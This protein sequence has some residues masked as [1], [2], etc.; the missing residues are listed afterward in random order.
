MS[1]FG[2]QFSIFEKDFRKR[3]APLGKRM[4]KLEKKINRL[5][6][7]AMSNARLSTVYWNGLKREMNILYAEMNGV[8]DLWSKKQIP[9]R[10]RK[11]IREIQLRIGANKAILDKAKKGAAQVVRSTASNQIMRGLYTSSV[12]SFLTSS[13][14]GRQNLR[15]LFI[16]TQQTLVEESLVNVAVGAGFEMGDL[17]QAKRLL[18]SIF[19]SPAWN[20][21]KNNQFVQAGRFKYKPSYYAELVARTKF[22]QAHSQA[23]LVQANN[24]G[25]DLV[26]V[27]S[28]NTTTKICMDFEGKIFSIRGGSKLFPP[29]TDSP[30]YHP[31]CLHLEFPTFQS[32]LETLGQTESFSAFS[33]GE[34]SRPPVPSGFVPVGDRVL[35]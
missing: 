16:A 1:N 32:A 24:H 34:I 4:A 20:V 14:A 18:T 21:V 29:L 3:F 2:G 31:N 12:E 28:H 10:Y 13:I 5:V 22:H 25:T 35:A 15:N 26:Q 17:R 7:R 11:S 33:K 9:L 27:S 8:F 19:Q 6:I 30:P 23:A